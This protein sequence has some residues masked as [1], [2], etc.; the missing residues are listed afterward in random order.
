MIQQKWHSEKR[1][2][3]N[4]DVVLVQDSN[5]VRGQW[6]KA[7]VVDAQISKDGK[8]RKATIT[9]RNDQGTRVEV[10]RP[11]QRLIVLVPTDENRNGETGV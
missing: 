11:V 9:Y 2:L 10:D 5:I 7:L 1:N 4:G 3:T 8:V 6:K